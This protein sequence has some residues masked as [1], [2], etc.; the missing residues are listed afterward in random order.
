MEVL[1]IT[2][3]NICVFDNQSSRKKDLNV[4]VVNS[5]LDITHI[6]IEF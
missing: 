1:S 6:K 3:E 4:H 5:Q 2:R